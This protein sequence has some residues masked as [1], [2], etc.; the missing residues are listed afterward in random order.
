MNPEMSKHLWLYEGCTEYAAQ[1]VQVKYELMGVDEFLDVMKQKMISASSF[2]SGIA[3]TEMSKKALDEHEDQYQ[4]VY[5]QGALIGMVLDLKLLHLSN[6]EY[7]IQDLMRDLSAEYGVDKPFEDDR[8]FLEIG[9][10]S[11]Y[12]QITPFLEKHVGGTEPLP[13]TE[14]LGYAGIEY[15]ESITK[16][17]VSGGGAAVG[18]NPRTDRMVVVGT[19]KLDKF[20]KDLGFEKGDEIVSWNGAEM[21]SDNF[22]SQL[23]TFKKSVS[24]GDKVTVIVARK[25]EDGTY[26]E[27]KLKAKVKTVERTVN[28][29]FE[30]KEDLTEEERRIRDA[31]LVG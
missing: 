19:D 21:S 7:G 14:V 31:W 12:L 29:Y 10:I 11:G 30:L 2:D 5:Q 27:K 1:H 22:R 16:N 24:V 4:N 25:K 13:Y 20:G 26:Q 18:F 8:L 3:F 23:Q 28:N 6:G 9:R 17:V 15:A